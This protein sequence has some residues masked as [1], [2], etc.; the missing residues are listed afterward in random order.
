[1]VSVDQ[2]GGNVLRLRDGFTPIPSMRA[3]GRA[4]DAE[5]TFAIGRLM[6]RELSAVGV[7]LDFA[8]V[9][10]VDTNP[11]NPVIGP[12][13]FGRTQ[14]LVS[15][16]GL[17][18]VSGLSSAGVADCGKHFP[19]HGDTLQDSHLDLPRLEHSLERLESLELVP[20]R[21]AIRAGIPALMTAHILFKE[22]DPTYPATMSP[23]IVRAV[24]RDSFGYD[25]LVISDDLEMK[26][27]ADHY[28]LEDV[29]VHGLNAGVDAFLCCHSPELMHRA[30]DLIA[31]AVAEG[32]IPTHRFEQALERMD[33]FALRWIT[34]PLERFDPSRVGT[35]EHRALV[36][37]VVQ[38]AGSN[39][40]AP[41]DPTEM[42]ERTLRD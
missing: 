5:L 37:R 1:L 32:K 11:D 7:D 39:S 18:L 36:E 30:I 27:I 21:A 2:E 10:D 20:F 38:S 29:L 31:A 16:H 4:D 23:L 13:S 8:P 25:G 40:I 6:G 26:A 41:E 3:V 34:S 35:Q 14:D 15:W 22:L 12:R 24:L 42:L 19:G 33:N 9:L 28:S 17:A